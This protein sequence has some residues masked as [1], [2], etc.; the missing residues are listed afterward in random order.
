M[1][2]DIKNVFVLLLENRSFDHML[3]FSG[4]TGKDATTG[5]TT[6]VN[7]LKGDE[8]NGHRGARYVVGKPFHEPLAVDPAHEFLDV[9]EQL[10]GTNA[11][12][13]SGKAYPPI[14]LGGFVSDYAHSH[15][16]GYGNAA[17]DFGQIMDGFTAAQLPVLN[18]LAVNFALCD[19][20][21]ASLPGP[22][23]P[24]RLFAMGASSNGLD[25]SPSTAE[26][27]TWE[28]ADGFG[29]PNGSIFGALTRRF[30][31]AAWR[32]Y[33]GNRFPLVSALRGIS[34]IEDVRL[35]DDLST[36][37]SNGPY[38]YRLTWIEPDY[39]DMVFGTFRGGSSQHPMDNVAGGEKLIKQVYE[40]IRRSPLWES[41]LLIVTWDEHGGFYDHV[42]PGQA[43][44]P[45]DTAPGSRYNQHGFTFTQLG[46]R[47]PAVIVSPRIPAGTIDHR[48]YDHS[49]IP[50]TIEEIFNL[51]PLT[52]RDKG[53]H[54]VETLLTLTEPRE[55]TPDSLPPYLPGGPSAPA[56]DPGS[57]SV[58]YGNLPLFLHIAMRHELALSDPRRRLAVVRRAQAIRTPAQA[59]RYLAE[60]DRRVSIAK[61][62]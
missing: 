35:I 32:I 54:S 15:T 25:H 10:C 40:S 48:P 29:F 17:G 27:L 43:V 42:A 37:L 7:G 53:A 60:I 1:S 38:P 2:A 33:A 9:L 18:A 49:A 21:H 3:G 46:V 30:G 22:T 44:A 51:P 55:D 31:D 5:A 36:D 34:P 6:Q 50:K 14:T 12:Y 11:V 19:G 41:S 39:G 4:I 61:A 23:F 28:G 16:K 52:Q 24:N 45:G 56:P 13:E 59:A 20:W 57:E 8:W 26:L 47:V 62:R 58:E